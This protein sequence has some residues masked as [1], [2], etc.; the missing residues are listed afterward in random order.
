MGRKASS[1]TDAS[2]PDCT[3][4]AAPSAEATYF[5]T[6]TRV[7]LAVALR[8]AVGSNVLEAL[9]ATYTPEQR[10][11]NSDKRTG[12]RRGDR[13][14]ARK[15]DLSAA[16]L[17]LGLERSGSTLRRRLR[18][19]VGNAY[20][21]ADG[22]ENALTLPY[23]PIGCRPL[24]VLRARQTLTVGHAADSPDMLAVLDAL[25]LP[26]ERSIREGLAAHAKWQTSYHQNV[27]QLWRDASP[28]LA[29]LEGAGTDQRADAIG[30][31]RVLLT[32][33]EYGK[34]QLPSYTPDGTRWNVA[35][36][37]A[38][39]VYGPRGPQYLIG[40]GTITDEIESCDTD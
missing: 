13:T 6:L 38:I 30:R 19:N 36:E 9:E 29:A 39:T 24:A 7:A 15:V 11:T 4:G 40:T 23:R 26:T 33:D 25:D 12:R 5:R 28:L 20:R 22:I 34:A 8:R 10:A 37:N 32:N 2:R 35:R 17:D 3:K 27:E 1:T 21:L 16:S 18:K 31:P 14:K